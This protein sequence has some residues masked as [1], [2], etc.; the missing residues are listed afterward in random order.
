MLTTFI[1][2]QNYLDNGIFLRDLIRKLVPVNETVTHF[3]CV[4]NF[5]DIRGSCIVFDIVQPFL[6]IT[7]STKCCKNDERVTEKG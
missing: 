1:Y 5:M 6:F 2:I 3:C 4:L 7:S